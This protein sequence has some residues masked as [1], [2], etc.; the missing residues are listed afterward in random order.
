MLVSLV[1]VAS[2][3]GYITRHAEPGARFA[4]AEDGKHFGEFLA[5]CDASI[6]GSGTWEADRGPISSGFAAHPER[7]RYVLTSRPGDYL[8]E[9]IPGTVEFAADTPVEAVANLVARGYERCALLGGGAIYG[10]FL[11]ADLV[12]ELA[13]TV[14]PLVFGAGVRWGTVA[15]NRRFELVDSIKLSAN[16]LLL[17][18]RRPTP[19][20]AG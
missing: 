19:Q 5:G 18:Y 16:T 11:A 2:L 9:A 15:V 14:E 6:F 10:A 1:A 4:S 12:D 8:H 13:L 7:L 17:T 3:D 20:P